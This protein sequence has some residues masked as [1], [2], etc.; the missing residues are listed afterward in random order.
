MLNKFLTILIF[1]LS[2]SLSN[3]AAQ[4]QTP[5]VID[6]GVVNGKATSL[7]VPKYPA[8]AL[9]V[10]ASGTVKVQ[11]TI[12]ENGSV[13]SASAI[14][15]HPLLRAASEQAARR[16][17]FSPTLLA[18]QPVKVTGII[19]YNFIA[20]AEKLKW[21]AVSATLTM[22]A[23]DN[24]RPEMEGYLTKLVPMAFADFPEEKEMLLVLLKTHG[25]NRAEV[26]NKVLAS[27]ENKL[28]EEKA[29]QVKLGKSF[30]EAGLE[31]RNQ[32][33]NA[34]YQS[35]E[36]KLRENLRAIGNLANTAP[37]DV[38][39]ETLETLKLIAGYAEKPALK[40]S[41]NL[42]GIMRSLTEF[43]K[44]VSPETVK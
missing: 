24:W 31:C 35:D 23:E 20:P 5:T 18:G 37:S 3:A 17:T 39:P 33:Y 34:D 42:V 6:G 15:G 13:I 21:T 28:P 14:S 41:E 8:A 19:A 25:N 43:I 26:I 2:F 22:A 10:K 32:I 9:A 29:W 7:P 11:V 38:S 16:A 12:D 27:L 30:G 44:T 4:T 36:N 1:A 40:D